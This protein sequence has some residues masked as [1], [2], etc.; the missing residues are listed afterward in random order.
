MTKATM[1]H[2]GGLLNLLSG[3]THGQVFVSVV[4]YQPDNSNDQLQQS[5]SSA[6]GDFSLTCTTNWQRPEPV[7][8]PHRRP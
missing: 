7:T 2:T 4:A 3:R 8:A 6:L 5:I 1:H